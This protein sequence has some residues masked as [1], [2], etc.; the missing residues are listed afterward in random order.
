NDLKILEELY[1]HTREDSRY[2]YE[3]KKALIETGI[4]EDEDNLEI[5]HL[6]LKPEFKKTSFYQTGQV[7][8]NRKIIKSYNNIRSFSDLGVKKRNLGFILS[9]GIGNNFSVFTKDDENTVGPKNEQKEIA[10]KEI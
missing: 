5:K 8:F 6:T 7:V 3:L 4:Y 2:I 9:S 1:Y 10:V